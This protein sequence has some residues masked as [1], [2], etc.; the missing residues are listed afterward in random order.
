MQ[1]FDSAKAEQPPVSS[2]GRSDLVERVEKHLS[3]SPTAR[4]P[5]A[6]SGAIIHAADS[7]WMNKPRTEKLCR[8][9]DSKATPAVN[10]YEEPY[11]GDESQSPT[12]QEAHSS[13]VTHASQSAEIWRAFR[14]D[15]VRGQPSHHSCVSSL[16]Q[17]DAMP[18]S[19]GRK[20]RWTRV[21][22]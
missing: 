17:L 22:L 9:Q 12:K 4:I 7:V 15:K 1:S 6:S 13:H 11:L 5:A 14:N 3:K 8:F 18:S 10:L 21:E 19:K 20:K 2:L 16:Q